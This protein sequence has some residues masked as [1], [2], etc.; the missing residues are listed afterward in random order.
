MHPPVV[1]GGPVV[2][3]VLLV[4]QAPGD[5]EPKLGRPFA[6]TA[7]KTLFRWFDQAA[8][9]SE[10]EFRASI[11]MAAVCR[12]FPGKNPAGGDRVPSPEEVLNCSVWLKREMDILKPELIIPV[13]KLAIAQ[14]LPLQK[15]DSMIGRNYKKI[16]AGHHFDVIPLPHPS[17]ASPWH[18]KEPGKSLLKKALRLIIKHPA[19]NFKNKGVGH[20]F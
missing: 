14:F 3:K 10:E 17:G 16:V 8:G 7:G 20:G 5:K 18:R 1:S 9:M 2:S 6:W 19:F 15:L 12:C 4:G 11:Y 13:G